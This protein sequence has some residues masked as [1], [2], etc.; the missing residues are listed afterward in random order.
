MSV[1]IQS[2]QLNNLEEIPVLHKPS[3]TVDQYHN[4]HIV[5]FLSKDKYFK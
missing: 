2:S 3:E 1:R 4:I 5:S